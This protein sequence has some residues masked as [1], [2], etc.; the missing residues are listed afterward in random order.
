MQTGRIPLS[1]FVPD[2]EQPRKLFQPGEI[3]ALGENMKAIGQQVP[4][5]VF[6]EGD[7]F[8]LID[9]Q[10]RWLGAK[11]A[12]KPD[13]LAMVLP[14]RPTTAQLRIIQNSLDVHRVSLNLMERSNLLAEIQRETGWG[15]SELAAQL[16]IK[17]SLCSKLLSYQKLAP[18]VQGLLATGAITD[19]EKACVLAQLPDHASQIAAVKDFGHLSRDAF[20]AKIKSKDAPAVKASR[21]MFALPGGETI[22]FKGQAATLEV[23][24]E[25]LTETLKRLRKGMN[26]GYD[27]STVQKMFRDQVR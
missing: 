19:L 21:A 17:Q 13:L 3:A 20:K 11:A 14:E 22:A 4:V 5:I 16:S 18:E 15:V 24:I 27:I 10:R 2:P 12:D 26:D 8:V 7:K 6:K 23:V 25:R 9:G 1:A